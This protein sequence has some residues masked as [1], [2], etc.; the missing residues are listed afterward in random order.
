MGPGLAAAIDNVRPGPMLQAL[1]YERRKAVRPA[2]VPAVHRLDARQPGGR[3][4]SSGLKRGLGL[5]CPLQQPSCF[6]LRMGVPRNSPRHPKPTQWTRRRPPGVGSNARTER[7]LFALDCTR[8]LRGPSRAA[9]R[10]PSSKVGATRSAPGLPS[11]S[12][13]RA[14]G[15]LN[16]ASHLAAAYSAHAGRTIWRTSVPP[17]ASMATRTMIARS[18][19]RCRSSAWPRWACAAATGVVCPS[20]TAPLAGALGGFNAAALPSVSPPRSM[21]N[22]Q[23]QFY[24]DWE[25]T[26]ESFDQ[27]NLHE[28]RRRLC[29]KETWCRRV[30]C[31]SGVHTWGHPPVSDAPALVYGPEFCRTCSGGSTLTA[32]SRSLVAVAVGG[33]LGGGR[34]SIGG[35]ASGGSHQRGSSQLALRRARPVRWPTGM[36]RGRQAAGFRRAARCCCCCCPCGAR[37]RQQGARTSCG[38]AARAR[39]LGGAH[40]SLPSLLAQVSRSP[41]PSSRRVSCL[42][43]RATT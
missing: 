32:S 39:G 34:P 8:T 35:P 40:R 16:A 29:A 33:H 18:T 3:E 30:L 14:S 15:L 36:A 37:A 5:K 27:M 41:R 10:T 12:T 11:R 20:I 7:L 31:T 24:T 22:N 9:P 6:W 1:V 4:G 42:S 23:D 38:G 28:V 26:F 43:A 25:E 2:A 17:R 13:S 21:S 19:R